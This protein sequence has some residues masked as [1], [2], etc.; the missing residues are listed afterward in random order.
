M[1]R[2]GGG[3]LRVAPCTAG[4]GRGLKEDGAAKEEGGGAEE[5]APGGSDVTETGMVAPVGRVA[6][7]EAQVVAGRGWVNLAGEGGNGLLGGTKV[8]HVL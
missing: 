5:G 2:G 1:G 7:P 6:E 8:G 3:G 4:S